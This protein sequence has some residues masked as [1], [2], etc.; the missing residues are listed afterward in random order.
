MF[1][2][3]HTHVFHNGLVL[4]AEVMDWLESAAF[5]LVLPAGCV[6]DPPQREGLSN[7]TSE[8]VQRGCGGRSSRQFIEDLERLGAEHTA[9]VSAPHTSFGA[10]MLAENLLS[11]LDIFADLVQRPHLPPDQLEEV[12]QVCLHEV[13]AVDDDP[14]QKVMQELRK[15]RYGS[16]WGRPS[17]GC[18]EALQQVTHQDVQRFFRQSYQPQ[19]A[20]LAVAGKIDWES[21][22]SHIQNILGEWPPLAAPPMNQ[23]TS[24]RRAL[25][26][27]QPA[28]QTHIGI[29]Y[30]NV[31]YG[32]KDYYQ[33]RGA[34][35][36]LSDGM[37]SRLFTE[38]RENRGLCYAVYATCHSLRD[39]GSVMCY[40]GTSTER[41][42]ETL[43]VLL[44]E[45]ARLADGI[46]PDELERLKARIKSALIMQQESS[47]ARS[48]A[49]A[50]DWYFLGRVQTMEEIRHI[51]DGLTC[52]SIN[53]FLR[54]NP[55]SDF[56]VVT[57]GPQSLEVPFAVS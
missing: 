53:R 26:I 55:P 40:A 35:G 17:Q 33:A 49:I 57:L 37:S 52:D 3:I 45:L 5:T 54:D 36:V 6:L 42:Q 19:G 15:L 30:P 28:S 51:V 44:M 22:K 14:A 43:D 12:R 13:R 2:L 4:V 16:P 24:E 27:P 47:A 38:V 8:M 1:R 31:P 21:L 23:S 48:T 18:E 39:R 32:H 11:V 41:A 25:H 34:V 10:A 20:I 7:L 9:S 29:A 50:G 46:R 56:T